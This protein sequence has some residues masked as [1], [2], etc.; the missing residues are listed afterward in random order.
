MHVEARTKLKWVRLVVALC[1]LGAT[2]SHGAGNITNSNSHSGGHDATKTYHSGGGSNSTKSSNSGGSNST[3]ISHSGTN[4]GTKSSHS[5]G[6]NTTKST[7][8]ASGGSFAVPNVTK[9][10]RGT[11]DDVDSDTP[12]GIHVTGGSVVSG[13]RVAPK[14]DAA[15][16]QFCVFSFDFDGTVKHSGED[17]VTR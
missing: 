14:T 6:Y 11:S 7:R 8:S 9:S 2:S 10:S 16:G 1:A 15:G 4:N 17:F 5:G 13:K 12:R 3:K